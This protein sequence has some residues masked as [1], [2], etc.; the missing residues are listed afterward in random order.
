MS[1][2][3]PLERARHC[4]RRCSRPFI[5]CYPSPPRVSKRD[6]YARCRVTIGR[7]FRV[8]IAAPAATR[9]SYSVHSW[10]YM[11]AL[12]NSITL[13][14]WNAGSMNAMA[15]GGRSSSAHI[16]HPTM[17]GQ[18]TRPCRN[19]SFLCKFHGH[20][21]HKEYIY[22][23]HNKMSPYNLSSKSRDVFISSVF[24]IGAGDMNDS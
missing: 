9:A 2:N 23:F 8:G 15:S 13:H 14:L 21:C 24:C 16:Q 19:L 4:I 11:H 6:V 1:G 22:S 7:K 17:L 18:I 10:G 12:S 5:P 3:G 20:S